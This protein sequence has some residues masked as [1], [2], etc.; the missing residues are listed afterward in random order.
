M[1]WI[2]RA[3]LVVVSFQFVIKLGSKDTDGNM[4]AKKYAKIKSLT[5]ENF[6]CVAWTFQDEVCALM[7]HVLFLFLYDLD[8]E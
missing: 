5:C 7:F 8:Y 3:F 6:V 4:K 1:D 2:L